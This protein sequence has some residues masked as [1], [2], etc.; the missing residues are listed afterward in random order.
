MPQ[1][2]IAGLRT[3]SATNHKA[4][5]QFTERHVQVERPALVKQHRCRGCGHNFC[6]AGNVVDGFR[7]DLRCAFFIG[8]GAQG[9]LKHRLAAAQNSKSAAGKCARGDGF[10][11]HAISSGKPLAR[12]VWGVVGLRDTW[13]H[14]CLAS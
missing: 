9:V 14:L 1:L 13:F 5:Q 11:E 4:W 3:G 10:F 8:E 12:A 7:G 6:Q 2:D